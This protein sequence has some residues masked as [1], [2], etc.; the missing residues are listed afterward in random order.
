MITAQHILAAII[1]NGLAILYEGFSHYF[2][3]REGRKSGITICH[4]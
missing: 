3:I 4:L 2:D 1:L